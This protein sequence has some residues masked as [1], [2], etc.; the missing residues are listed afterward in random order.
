MTLK[1]RVTI[2]VNLSSIAWLQG[3][4]IRQYLLEKRQRRCACCGKQN[5]P[6]QIEHIQVRENGGT[7]RVSNLTLDF[8]IRVSFFCANV[9][10]LSGLLGH[11]TV[12]YPF[13]CT[14]RQGGKRSDG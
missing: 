10:G 14:P 4:E 9:W 5:S 11:S 2:N 3:F 6:L 12:K 8:A 7:D 1:M 13:P